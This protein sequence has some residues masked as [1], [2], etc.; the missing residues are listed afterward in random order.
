MLGVV[1]VSYIVNSMRRGICCVHNKYGNW[2]ENFP[3]TCVLDESS[4]KEPV[5]L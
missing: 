1:R 4:G 2:L 3:R 5:Y